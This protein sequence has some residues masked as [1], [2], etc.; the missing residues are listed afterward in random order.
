[1]FVLGLFVLLLLLF[2]GGVGGG[3]DPLPHSLPPAR[4][5]G[6]TDFAK[7]ATL[8]AMC[9]RVSDVDF[10]PTRLQVD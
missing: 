9:P 7:T 1:M 10:E 4:T 5:H 8:M 6:V 3:G 2:F